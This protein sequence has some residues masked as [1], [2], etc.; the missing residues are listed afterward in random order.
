MPRW[1]AMS[2]SEEPT[3]MRIRREPPTFRSVTVRR[4]DR[5]SPRMVRVIFAGPDLQGLSVDQPAASVRL[6][7]PSSRGEALVMPAWTG[8]EFLLPDGRRPA[9]R[10][11][12]PRHVDTDALELALDFV[13]HGTGVASAWAEAATPGD[14]RRRLRSR[15]RAT[16]SMPMHPPSCWPVTRPPSR[17]S[18]S[19]SRRC[20]MTAR[21]RCTS[22]SP[23][24]DGRL[25]LPHHP[26]VALHWHDLP[27]GAP[28]GDAI[29]AAV[30]DADDRTRYPRVG[31]RR[32]R[33]GATNSPPAV[34][35]TGRAPPPRHD[36]WL[37]EAR[38]RRRGRRG[39]TATAPRTGRHPVAA[40]SNG[41]ASAA[42]MAPAGGSVRSVR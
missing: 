42:Q 1:S 9:I 30:G 11:F 5:L 20:L 24:P 17:P 19:C 32:S 18:A 13:V 26:L 27:E 28:A 15:P 39:L 22:R 6:L 23:A 36:P 8:N 35:G 41:W 14:A 12:T 10:T 38:P 40:A 3:T 29:V 33:R 7:L 31:R 21:S 37:L 34:R 16:P 25:D 4:V 2:G